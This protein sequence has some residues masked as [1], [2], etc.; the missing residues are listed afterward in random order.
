MWAEV[1]GQVFERHL[2]LLRPRHASH[3]PGGHPEPDILTDRA[4]GSQDTL[5]QGNK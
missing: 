4:A 5:H 3:H 1:P 2:L